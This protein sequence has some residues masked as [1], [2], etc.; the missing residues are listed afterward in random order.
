MP[1]CACWE[2]DDSAGYNF[3]PQAAHD[4]WSTGYVSAHLQTC[5]NTDFTVEAVLLR[6]AGTSFVS[7]QAQGIVVEQDEAN[8]IV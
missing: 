5:T 3:A 1:R 6:H 7:Y 4:L 2:Q 8:L